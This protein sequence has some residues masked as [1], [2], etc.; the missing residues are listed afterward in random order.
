[1]LTNPKISR[2]SKFEMGQTKKEETLEA[3]EA[4]GKNPK[5]S[6]LELPQLQNSE[7]LV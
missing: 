4:T 1:M 3:M 6:F 2:S 5:K 7:K